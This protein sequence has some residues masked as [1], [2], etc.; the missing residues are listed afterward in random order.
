ME[1]GGKISDL[2]QCWKSK[3]R[4]CESTVGGTGEMVNMTTDVPRP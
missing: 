4:T 1:I 2:F 3:F